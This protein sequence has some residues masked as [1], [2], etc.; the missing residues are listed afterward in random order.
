MNEINVLMKELNLVDGLS[1]PSLF[2]GSPSPTQLPGLRLHG[3][4]LIYVPFLF[5]LSVLFVW[6]RYMCA[7]T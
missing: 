7:E 2:P 6:Y 3:L 5:C 4:Y 1:H